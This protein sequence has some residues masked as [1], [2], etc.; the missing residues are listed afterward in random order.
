MQRDPLLQCR[1][2]EPIRSWPTRLHKPALGPGA[3]L[4]LRLG[5]APSVSAPFQPCA[6]CYPD[7]APA[8]PSRSPRT[9]LVLCAPHAKERS[10]LP[11]A[12]ALCSAP[13]RRHADHH[14]QATTPSTGWATVELCR[15]RASKLSHEELPR[16]KPM[17]CTVTTETC[18]T[19]LSGPRMDSD[20]TSR[21]QNR[22]STNNEQQ[23]H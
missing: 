16:S 17:S 18:L 6:L 12:S 20:Q 14:R 10:F 11:I 7:R 3:V 13:S 9:A 23:N 8:A 21:Q 4:Q 15:P 1:M 2:P 19:L 22:R 5:A